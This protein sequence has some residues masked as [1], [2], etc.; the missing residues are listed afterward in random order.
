MPT[1]RRIGNGDGRLKL[2]GLEVSKN[3]CCVGMGRDVWPVAA[4]SP[5]LL[6][7]AAHELRHRL[8][9]DFG[10]VQVHE[11]SGVGKRREAYCC[12]GNGGVEW[13]WCLGRRGIPNSKI[14]QIL[15]KPVVQHFYS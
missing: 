13:G 11:E 9:A 8:E 10:N 12:T 5:P 14:M 3:C 6:T 4:V 15:H 7:P 2:K 1:S